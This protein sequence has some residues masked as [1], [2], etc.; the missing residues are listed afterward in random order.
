MINH[1]MVLKQVRELNRKNDYEKTLKFLNSIEVSITTNPYYCFHYGF[2]L[3]ESHKEHESVKYFKKAKE[4]GIEDIDEL[5][6]TFYPKSIEKWIERAEKNAPRRLEKNAFEAERRAKRAF[7]IKDIDYD[8]FDF[9]NFWDDCDT[10]K[11][12]F[13]CIEKLNQHYV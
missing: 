2:S 7:S 12:V 1:D 8:K 6:N 11:E 9:E 3:H 5:P 13:P 10:F 4:L